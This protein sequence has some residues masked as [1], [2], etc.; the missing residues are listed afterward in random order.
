MNNNEIDERMIDQIKNYTKVD[1]KTIDNIIEYVK[2]NNNKKEKA[3]FSCPTDKWKATVVAGLGVFIIFGLVYSG[4]NIL[5][6]NNNIN[7]IENNVDKVVTQDINVEYD[8]DVVGM[9]GKE[10]L[11]MFNINSYKDIDKIVIRQNEL[12]DLSWIEEVKDIT[13]YESTDI[14]YFYDNISNLIIQ[15]EPIGL[16]DEWEINAPKEREI[17][18]YCSDGSFQRIHYY[19]LSNGLMEC[20]KKGDNPIPQ[21]TFNRLSDDFN[22]WLI[23]LCNIDVDK[24]YSDEYER[25][26]DIQKDLT[27]LQKCETKKWFGGYDVIFEDV[28]KIKVYL[29]DD[30]KKN[31][32]IILNTVAND[33]NV[34][35]VE[36]N[37]IN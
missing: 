21:K 34:V 20:F 24:D 3:I 37:S 12:N 19:P 8:I 26:Q 27:L 6:R 30:N 1:S 23:N 14:K 31:R 32:N 17:L 33:E 35:F 4:I 25:Y 5:S 10:L 29:R 13:I 2:T 22:K 16:D 18:L 36:K 28:L 11:K 9:S 15:E 7:I